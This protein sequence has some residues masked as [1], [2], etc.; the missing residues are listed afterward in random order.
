MCGRVDKPV[1][2]L[3]KDLR[4]RGLLDSTLVVWC[5]EFGRTP[6]SQGGKG[7]DHNP[8]GY[9]MWLA[10]GGVKGGMA[11]GETDEIGLYAMKQRVSVNDFH[12]TILHL[13][14]MDHE[15]LTYLHN[16]RAERLTDVAGRVIEPILK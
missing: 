2:A 8:Y 16:G 5:S 14:G 12:A 6:H 13:L 1:A 3:L 4:Q 9:T 7:R 11:Y 15:K 10:G